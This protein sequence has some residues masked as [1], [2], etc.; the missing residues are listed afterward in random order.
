MIVMLLVTCGVT[1]GAGAITTEGVLVGA[2]TLGVL[3]NE[4]CGPGVSIGLGLALGESDGLGLA[5]GES[6]GLG[7]GLVLG[8]ADGLGLA[9]GVGAEVRPSHVTGTGKF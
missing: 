4:S 6:D 8:E 1:A 5:L 9:L 7:L 2:F 3:G